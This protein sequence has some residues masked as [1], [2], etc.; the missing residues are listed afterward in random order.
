MD[1]TGIPLLL[2]AHISD[3]SEG[4]IPP[5]GPPSTRTRTSTPR[6]FAAASDAPREGLENSF[7]Y[8][9]KPCPMPGILRP[10]RPHWNNPVKQGNTDTF[11]KTPVVNRDCPIIRTR[12]SR[13]PCLQINV[14]C[15]SRGF[16]FLATIFSAQQC[17]IFIQH[18]FVDVIRQTE[19]ITIDNTRDIN[20]ENPAIR[21]PEAGPWLWLYACALRATVS[22]PRITVRGG[23]RVPHDYLILLYCPRSHYRKGQGIHS[24][25]RADKDQ[26]RTQQSV[27]LHRDVKHIPDRK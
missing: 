21:N 8:L 9:Q 24:H 14:T 10:Q 3:F 5:T 18:Q 12:G 7:R 22:D 15:P 13:I 6:L 11:R 27:L 26:D 2:T 20:E 17:P 16:T 23:N 25:H 4:L 19:R 1:R